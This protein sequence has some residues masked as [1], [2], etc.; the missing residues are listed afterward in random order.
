M[1]QYT[2][3]IPCRTDE[4][5]QEHVILHED[6]NYSI[7]L[8]DISQNMK[9]FAI[10]LG[11][12]KN[13][14]DTEL[15]LGSLV[16][17]GAR[18][19]NGPEVADVI[20]VNTCGFLESAVQES[21]DA[22][23]EVAEH[24]TREQVLAVTG[25][26]VERYGKELKQELPEVD[27]FHGTERPELVAQKIEKKLH[28]MPGKASVITGPSNVSSKDHSRN[29]CGEWITAGGRLVTTP[30]WR[31]FVRIAEGCSNRCTYCLIPSIRGRNICRPA[32]EIID[33]IR[34][35][36]AA[37]VREIT[38]LAQDLTSYRHDRTDLA[39]L[40]RTIIKETDIGWLRLLYLHPAGLTT[41]LLQVMAENDTRICPYLDIPVQHA[42]SGILKRMGR[43]YDE[44]HLDRLFS[45]ARNILPHAAFRTTVMVG[46]PGESEADFQQLMEFIDRHQFMHLGCF[47]Y[48]D[49]E[50]CA[51]HGLDGK[52][53]A[54]TANE[55][56]ARI[57]EAQA[58]ISQAINQRFVGKTLKVLIEGISE[59]TD[60]LLQGRTMLQAPEVDGITYIAE[61]M[62][63]QVISWM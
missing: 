23:L 5:V 45:M 58:G 6:N 25:C 22:I 21:I 36:S 50:E 9:I 57:M 53:D 16:P 43:G 19:V 41:E 1:L 47:V 14:I 33:E 24:K 27:I 4:V 55:R 35:L 12:A 39:G 42:A 31:A 32:D 46:F 28:A 26:M 8:K 52:V 2:I 60:L 3:K 56:K 10:S 30:P 20:L 51:A 29:A 49:E 11:C 54:E 44:K 40:A 13:S 59:E 15:I 7:I 61:G 48:S 62:P 63:I 34:Q 38:L 17:Q 18:L 37:G